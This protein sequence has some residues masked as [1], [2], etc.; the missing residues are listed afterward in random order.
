MQY[1][2]LLAALRLTEKTKKIAQ[3]KAEEYGYVIKNPSLVA[4]RPVDMP[5]F[6]FL[7]SNPKPPRTITR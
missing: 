4:T 6:G 3:A 1:L 5:N 7:P 2:I